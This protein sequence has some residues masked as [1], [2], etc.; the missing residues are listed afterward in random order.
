MQFPTREDFC[1]EKTQVK[2]HFKDSPIDQDASISGTDDGEPEITGNKTRD[3]N[4]VVRL[5]WFL[6]K[7]GDESGLD[8][9]EQWRFIRSIDTGGCNSS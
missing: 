8:I 1:C 6:T 7:L 9:M 3:N 4:F 5:Q 2:L